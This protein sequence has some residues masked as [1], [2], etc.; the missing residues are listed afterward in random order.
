MYSPVP[1]HEIF[2][3]DCSS[4][5]NDLQ[6][7]LYCLSWQLFA[8][9]N[10]LDSQQVFPDVQSKSLLLLWLIPFDCHGTDVILFMVFFARPGN[11]SVITETIVMVTFQLP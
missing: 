4:F 6:R 10:N 8:L 11:H 1:G 2:L 5:F 7:K 3:E 9:P